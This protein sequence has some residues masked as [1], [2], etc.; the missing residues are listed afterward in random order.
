[1][2]E[3]TIIFQLVIDE[4]LEAL[5]IALLLAFNSVLSLIQETRSEKTFEFLRR[6][7][8][9]HAS[10]LRNGQWKLLPAAELVPT[11]IVKLSRGQVVP[12]DTR[13]LEGTVL[14]DQS[15]LS[16]ESA[17]VEVSTGGTCFSGALV[18]QFC[19]TAPS[20]AQS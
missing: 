4:R 8:A 5:V 3:A 12:A 20:E 6:R 11:D 13:V 16:G 15:M 10:V 14:L 9:P 17:T 18:R 7:L 2:L 1:M 19:V